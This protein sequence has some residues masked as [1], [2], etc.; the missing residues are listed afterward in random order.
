M[1]L[2]EQNRRRVELLFDSHLSIQHGL[3]DLQQ[4]F[5]VT[6]ILKIFVNATKDK[7]LQNCAHQQ[8]NTVFF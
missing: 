2:L 6:N 1:I 5:A 4:G 7:Y 8:L 3:E